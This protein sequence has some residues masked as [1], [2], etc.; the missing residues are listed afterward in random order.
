MKAVALTKGLTAQVDQADIEWVSALKWFSQGDRNGKYYAARW[1][2]LPSGKRKEIRM[3]R[4]IA[5]RM[6]GQEIADGLEVDH[7]NLD[8]LDNRRCNL[9][10]CTKQENL[11]RKGRYKNNTS[12]SKGVYWDKGT[13]KWR[14]SLRM[15]GRLKYLGIFADKAE[16]E[17]VYREAYENYCKSWA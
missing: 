5:E 12:G 17:A 4:M 15:N 3:H 16:A 13:H 10:V 6:M 11:K 1:K 9:R 14:A 2:R 7:I 8:T